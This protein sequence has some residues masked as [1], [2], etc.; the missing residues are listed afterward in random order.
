MHSGAS[1]SAEAQ[2]A[3]PGTNVSRCEL[4]PLLSWRLRVSATDENDSG[5]E[6]ACNATYEPEEPWHVCDPPI[7]QLLPIKAATPTPRQTVPPPTDTTPLPNLACI[8]TAYLTQAS[9]HP[10]WHPRATLCPRITTSSNLM[11]TQQDDPSSANKVFSLSSLTCSPSPISFFSGPDAASPIHLSPAHHPSL[12]PT[13]TD[14]ITEYKEVHA[15][16]SV[17]SLICIEA[18]PTPTSELGDYEDLPCLKQL[19]H[20]ELIYPDDPMEGATSI[21]IDM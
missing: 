7:Q 6:A 16:P 18:P 1:E 19:K 4:T 15:L 8:K 2:E 11:A 12:V 14:S 5:E 3:P 21:S 17:C 13:I 9:L 20:Q 10:Y